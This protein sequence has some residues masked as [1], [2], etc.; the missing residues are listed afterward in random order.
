MKKLQL[1]KAPGLAVNDKNAVF[2]KMQIL[3]YCRI[4]QVLYRD[5][6]FV[7]LSVNI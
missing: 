1:I 7:F 5:L 2:N 6:F 4:S 3:S